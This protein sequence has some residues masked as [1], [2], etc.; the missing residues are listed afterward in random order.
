MRAAPRSTRGWR[1]IPPPLPPHP[2]QTTAT[3]PADQQEGN[4]QAT[5]EE[6]A[7]LPFAPLVVISCGA[8]SVK[9]SA[10][11]DKGLATYWQSHW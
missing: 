11:L 8:G 9:D 6:L 4:H 3:P 5:L 2:P 7:K 1:P 10:I